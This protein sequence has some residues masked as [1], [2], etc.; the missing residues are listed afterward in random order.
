[1]LRPLQYRWKRRYQVVYMKN[2]K[3]AS[4]FWFL[5][6][7]LSADLVVAVHKIAGLVGSFSTDKTADQ[8]RGVLMC[9][10]IKYSYIRKCVDSVLFCLFAGPVSV[11]TT[12]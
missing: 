11:F 9:F 12:R 7:F 4:F 2:Q 10:Y 3:R 6:T 1:M 8:L 5:N